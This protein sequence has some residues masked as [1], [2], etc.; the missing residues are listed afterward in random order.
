MGFGSLTRR[1]IFFNPF[2]YKE[3]NNGDGLV[4]HHFLLF[5]N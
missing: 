1:V 5:D 3:F 2:V 4:F